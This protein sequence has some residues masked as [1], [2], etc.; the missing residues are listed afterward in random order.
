M[1]KP[2][3]MPAMATKHIETVLLQTSINHSD[4]TSGLDNAPGNGGDN[5][6]THNPVKD[7]YGWE[8]SWDAYSSDDVVSIDE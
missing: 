8:Y 5:D 1:K 4:P 2:Y 7:R 3:I 6:G